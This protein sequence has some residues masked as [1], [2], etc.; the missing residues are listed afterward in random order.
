MN[1]K[2]LLVATF[3]SQPNKEED[4]YIQLFILLASQSWMHITPTHVYTRIHSVPETHHV[5]SMHIF[6]I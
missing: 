3:E 5:T 6:K 1:T 4:V 2:L